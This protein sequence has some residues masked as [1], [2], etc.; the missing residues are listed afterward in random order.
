MRLDREKT[1]LLLNKAAGAYN[2]EVNDLLLTALA[3]GLKA[4]RGEGS[5]LV[6]LEG[7]G[8]ESINDAIDVSGTIGWFTTMYPVRL[9]VKS[10]S[11]G[12]HQAQQ[13]ASADDSP[14]KGL[15]FGALKYY[16]AADAAQR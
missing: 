12:Q 1:A 4:V 3:Y 15:G 10:T 2:T 5:C 14:D 9:E 16:R 13:G 7:H 6:T 11:Q 8:R